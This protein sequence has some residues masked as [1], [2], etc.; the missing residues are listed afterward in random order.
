MKTH[1]WMLC[2]FGLLAPLQ[3]AAADEPQAVVR[4]TLGAEGEGLERIPA[5]GPLLKLF[6]SGGECCAE[7]PCETTASKA[8]E[9][10][11]CPQAER[12]VPLLSKIPYVS[13]LFTNVGRASCDECTQDCELADVDCP[14]PVDRNLRLVGADGLERIGIEF[15]CDV[16]AGCA[17]CETARCAPAVTAYPTRPP[18]HAAPS[19]VYGPQAGPYSATHAPGYAAAAYHVLPA[20]VAMLPA[21]CFVGRDEL[22]EALMEARVEAAVAQ[23]ALKVRE[24]SD[25][26]QLELIGELLSSQIENAK[27]TAKLEL[28]AEKEKLV[29]ELYEARVELTALQAHVAKEEKVAQPK[30]PRKNAEARRPA[31]TVETLR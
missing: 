2:C 18:H 29:A 28:A 21:E 31:K 4:F 20:P 16:T 26:K 10:P 30:R 12:G 13:R 17:P 25:E 24:E 27:L 8:D 14:G 1:A 23:T 22:I 11:A 15:D 5:V 19:A 3:L 9:C 6:V 7:Q